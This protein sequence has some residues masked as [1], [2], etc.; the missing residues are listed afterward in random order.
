MPRRPRAPKADAPYPPGWEPFLA[1][2]KAEAFDDTP[3]L[4]FAD[5]LD[6]NGD[7]ARAEFI[8]LQIRRHPLRYDD[9]EAK[10]LDARGE[11]L[12]HANGGRWLAGFPR[13]FQ[14]EYAGAFDR[15]FVRSCSLTGAKFL[16][17]GGAI[18]RLTPI[19][20]LDLSR[21]TPEAL[22]CP[23]L[24]EVGGLHL[25]IVDS[26]RAEALAGHPNLA[27]LRCLFVSNGGDNGITYRPTV[28][29]SREA[30]RALLANRSLSGLW[31]LEFKCWQHGDAVAFGIAAGSFTRLEDLS[32]YS[33]ELSAEGLKAL[34]NSASAPALTNLHIAGNRFGDAGIRH[35]V[36]APG[37]T[38]LECLNVM[39]C[40]LTA[41]SARL[42]AEWPGLRTVRWLQLG[43]GDV[44]TD[45]DTDR[46]RSSPHAVALQDRGARP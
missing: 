15:G 30:I 20:A 4:V 37:L 17:D 24:S 39:S 18:T 22:R 41:E 25:S 33:S 9:P 26:A 21:I 43:S 31:R 19:D 28:R 45:A 14:K 16:A 1:A 2:I 23:A 7:P 13:W 29:L 44:L 34:V 36:E 5:W 12:L 8:R 11:E 3:R 32:L 6:E 42:L 10:E 38:R 46:I 35:L 40:G 27:N